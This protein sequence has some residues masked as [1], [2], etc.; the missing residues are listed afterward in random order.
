MSAHLYARMRVHHVFGANTDIGKTVFTTGLSIA[1]DAL[2]CNPAAV[3]A[4]GRGEQAFYCKPVQTGPPD[5]WDDAHVL[6]YAPRTRASRLFTLPVALSPHVA[7]QARL[8]GSAKVPSDAELVAAAQTWLHATAQASSALPQGAQAI[9]EPAGGV[10]SPT[11]A[12]RSLGSVLRALRAP[13]VL[14]GDSRLGGISATRS[15]YDSLLLLGYDVDTILLFPAP[16]ETGTARYLRQLFS[17]PDGPYGTRNTRVF[18]LGGPNGSDTWGPPP[19]R[20]AND[21]TTMREFYQ[22]LVFGRHDQP[23]GAEQDNGGLLGAVAHLRKRH[24]ERIEDLSAMAAET[25]E[26]CWWPFTQHQLTRSNKDVMVIDSAYGDTFDVLSGA[27]ST[28]VGASSSPTAPDPPS[29]STGAASLLQPVFDGSASWWTQTL[30]HADERLTYAAAEA[31]GRYGHVL[32]PTASSKPSLELAKRL[33]GTHASPSHPESGSGAAS[34]TAVGAKWASR[35]FFSDDGSTGMEV[36][37]KMGLASS[38]VRYAPDSTGGGQGEWAWDILGLRGSYHGDTIGAMDACEP[39]PYSVMVDWYQPRGLWFTPPTLRGTRG[40]VRVRVPAQVRDVVPSLPAEVEG[41]TMASMYDLPRRLAHE[42]ELV[43]AYQAYIKSTIEAY[44]AT[45]QGQGRRLGALVMEPLVLGAGGMQFVDPLFQRV[46]VDAVRMHPSWFD[47]ATSAGKT[48]TTP[49]GPEWSGLPVIFDE[50]FAG[51]HRLGWATCA[52]ALGVN[53]DVAVYAKMLTGGVVPMAVTLANE[54]IFRTF[55]R[56]DKK[57]DALLHGHSYTAYPAGC[58]VANR[59][60]SILDRS[61]RDV[62]STGQAQWSLFSGSDSKFGPS[63]PTPSSF[64]PPPQHLDAPSRDA[65]WSLWS[66]ESVAQL[67]ATPGVDSALALG[68][69]LVVELQD[70]S[71]SAGYGSGAAQGVLDALRRPRAGRRSHPTA[72]E[73]GA[74]ELAIHAR[75]LGNVLYL[76]ASINSSPTTLRHVEQRLHRSIVDG[77]AKA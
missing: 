66:P 77:L 10:H 65:A 2:P 17:D 59:T 11:P 12:G 24:Q 21:E 52:T 14:V 6:R 40:G 5:S 68:C 28:G 62:R 54:S 41:G 23:D 74:D 29:P 20:G 16:G 50:V 27:N 73:G 7:A 75:P 33:L 71:S 55:A 58:A 37:L 31:L 70:T 63:S 61:V 44:R 42:P 25:R 57:V 35:V 51:M 3:P 30:G 47:A 49:S 1:A 67:A 38:R 48:T 36:A 39:G 18:A 15:A 72:A 34:E 46:L 4:P 9:I 56:S 69:V 53:P 13:A 45:H 76:M 8:R 60:L 26:T 32:F 19:A 22:G 64:S 43:A